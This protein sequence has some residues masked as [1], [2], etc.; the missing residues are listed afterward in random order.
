MATTEKVLDKDQPF[1][2][3][4]TNGDIIKG[5]L[6]LSSA[7]EDAKE[8]NQRASS[9]GLQARYLASAKP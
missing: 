9:L 6:D 2:V 3:C 1:R 4:H 5:F 7:T 8:R